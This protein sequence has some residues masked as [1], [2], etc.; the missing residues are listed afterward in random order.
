MSPFQTAPYWHCQMTS[1]YLDDN[2]YA[3]ELCHHRVRE[4]ER[5]TVFA[6]G[7]PLA[8]YRNQS[9]PHSNVQIITLK[10]YSPV[11][12]RITMSCSTNGVCFTVP[13]PFL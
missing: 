12:R 7:A 13:E 8:M 2:S 1:N 9:S 6:S 5:A 3:D 11:S 4:Q 10:L